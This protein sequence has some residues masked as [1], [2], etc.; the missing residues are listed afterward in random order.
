M[1]SNLSDPISIAGRAVKEVVGQDAELAAKARALA[2]KCID[3]AN[4]YLDNGAPQVQLQVIKSIM[5][6]IGRGMSEKGEDE[7]IAQ[8]RAELAALHQAVLG[9]S[10]A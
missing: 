9:S 4:H 7:S 8:L 1:A 10:V 2:D 3:I 5:P 6:A